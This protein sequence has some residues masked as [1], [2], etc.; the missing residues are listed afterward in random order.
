[1]VTVTGVEHYG[2]AGV[3]IALFNFDDH[4]APLQPLHA[5]KKPPDQLVSQR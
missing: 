1:M 5:N 2:M 4:I 3:R